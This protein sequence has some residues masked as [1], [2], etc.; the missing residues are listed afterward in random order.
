MIVT[1]SELNSNLYLYKKNGPLIN[2]DNL[3]ICSVIELKKSS[4]VSFKYIGIFHCIASLNPKL[5]FSIA[6]YH[7]TIWLGKL[8]LQHF[9]VQLLHGSQKR[10][11]RSGLFTIPKKCIDGKL[12]GRKTR[13]RMEVL[14]GLKSQF[15]D[16]PEN[17]NPRHG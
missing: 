14:R 17:A 1:L 4:L 3:K 6:I 11:Q 13:G 9:H 2:L 12:S 15:Q 16:S 10:L 8:Y 7:Q 5:S